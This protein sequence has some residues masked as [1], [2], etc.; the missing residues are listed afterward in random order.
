MTQNIHRQVLLYGLVFGMLCFGLAWWQWSYNLLQISTPWYAVVLCAVF[1]IFGLWLGGQNR[2][3]EEK[4][5]QATAEHQDLLAQL[6]RRENEILV[7]LV[8][9]KSNQ[10]IAESL[11]LSLSTVKNHVSNIYGKLGTKNRAATILWYV[12]ET[13]STKEGDLQ[14]A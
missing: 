6:S 2:R 8:S 14:S 10:Q 7:E 13:K 4:P 11:F 5:A 1:L 3:K 12:N 9:G